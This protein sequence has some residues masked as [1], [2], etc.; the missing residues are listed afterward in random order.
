MMVA[1]LF[2]LWAAWLPAPFLHRAPSHAA[3]GPHRGTC[4]SMKLNN[5]QQQLARLMEA[6]ERQR[7]GLA[8]IEE[9][10][11][12]TRPKPKAKAQPKRKAPTCLLY[13]SPSPRDS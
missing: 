4:T 13:T 10:P 6:A 2:M 8:P 11:A 1:Q 12:A 5:K 9:P 7:Q 3:L